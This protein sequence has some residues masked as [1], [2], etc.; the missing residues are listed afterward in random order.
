[1]ARPA[2]HLVTFGL[3]APSIIL[4]AVGFL[5]PIAILA[6]QS[7]QGGYGI[8]TYLRIFETPIYV[9]VLLRTCL[10][11]GATALGCLFLAFPL[12]R[13]IVTGSPLLRGVL[14]G[15]VFLPFW[16]N[17]LVLA[18]G[19]IV[20]L[21][22]NGAINTLLLTLSVIA[23]PLSLV[24]NFGSVLVGMIQILLPY[25]VLPLV[26]VM[27][28]IDPQLTR[29]AR[30]LGASPPRAFLLVYLP[31]T[32]PGL[33]AGM[34]LTFCCSLGF[35][36]IPAI[37][38]GTRDITLAQLIEYNINTSL[39]WGFAGALSV[40]LLAVTL[41]LFFVANRWFRLSSIWGGGT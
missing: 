41:A 9:R 24:N 40:L 36:V 13:I 35:F 23:R 17:F 14:L 2:S 27:S 18:Y 25:A 6:A 10:L 26:A 38:G 33:M 8:G 11:G 19:W 12:A 3:L 34:L 4:L 16:C 31:Q 32:L 20:L 1:M 30:S 5:Y 21:N 29:A 22:P 7:F 37:L 28:R 15:L 39:D